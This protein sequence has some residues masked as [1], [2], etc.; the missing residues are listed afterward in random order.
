MG[1]RVS[2]LPAAEIEAADAIDWY[3]EKQI[4][5]GDS[6]L[7]ALEDAIAAIQR[8]PLAFPVVLG[9]SVRRA[10]TQRFPYSIIYTVTG[11][12]ILIIAVFHSSRNPIIWRG[13]V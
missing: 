1:R 9:S 11:E 8:D 5:L 13:R 2:F 12:E 6:F 7:K 3:G 10:L 4:G